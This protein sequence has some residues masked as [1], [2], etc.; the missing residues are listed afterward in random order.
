MPVLDPAGKGDTD[1]CHCAVPGA[2]AVRNCPPN[3]LFGVA[4]GCGTVCSE[5][6]LDGEWGVLFWM[7]STAWKMINGFIV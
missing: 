2:V 5:F 3:T 6:R 1:V 7:R 4:A